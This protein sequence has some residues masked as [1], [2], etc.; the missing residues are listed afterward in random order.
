M[1]VGALLVAVWLVT[2]ILIARDAHIGHEQRPWYLLI[3]IIVPPSVLWYHVWRWSHGW[4]GK[5]RD[6]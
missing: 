2:V 1:L 6:T 5:W 3:A 4:P